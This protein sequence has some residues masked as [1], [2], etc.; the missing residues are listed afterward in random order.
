MERRRPERAPIEGKLTFAV[1]F[2]SCFA[3]D[4]AQAKR[5]E[6]GTDRCPFWFHAGMGPP[7]YRASCGNKAMRLGPGRRDFAGMRTPMRR[8]AQPGFSAHPPKRRA[9]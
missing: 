4:A 2:R 1:T 7:Q 8:F 9:G 5:Q 6:S 3:I